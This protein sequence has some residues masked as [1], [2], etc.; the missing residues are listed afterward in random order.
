MTVRVLIS[1]AGIAGLTLAYWLRRYGFEP[2]IVEK[3]PALRE[4]GYMIDFF[5]LGYDVAERMGLRAKL[6]EHDLKITEITFVDAENRAQAGLRTESI[7]ALLDNRACNIL[8][9][10]LSRLL[11]D[12]AKDDARSCS[13]TPSDPSHVQPQGANR[14]HERAVARIRSACRRRWAPLHGPNVDI[15]GGG[16]V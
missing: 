11:Y 1:G 7:R 5:G 16:S 10:T 14:V 6:D 2:T 13:G 12:A 4:G 8:R 9:G 3:A 15:R